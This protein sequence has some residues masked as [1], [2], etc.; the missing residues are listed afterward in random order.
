MKMKKQY[1]ALPVVAG[2]VGWAALDKTPTN[3]TDFYPLR[4]QESVTVDV[5]VTPA[6]QPLLVSQAATDVKLAKKLGFAQHLPKDVEFLLGAYDLMGQFNSFRKSKLGKVIEKRMADAGAKIDDILN[7]QEII[8]FTDIAGEEVFLSV[9]YGGGEQFG[10]FLTV[11]DFYTKF[12]TSMMIQ[13]LAIEMDPD[14]NEEGRMMEKQNALANAFK[15]FLED[16]KGG[17]GFLNKLDTPP[18]YAGF[19]VTNKDNRENYTEMLQGFFEVPLAQQDDDFKV[20]EEVK[21]KRGGGEFTGFK[22][23]GK[24]LSGQMKGREF[25]EMESLFGAKA[26]RDLKDTVSKK[27]FYAVVGN[28]GDHVVFFFGASLDDFKL[29]ENVGESLLA[30]SD[31]KFAHEFADKEILS[32]VYASEGMTSRSLEQRP[33]GAYAEGLKLGLENT[34]VFGDTRDFEGLVDHVAETADDLSD[35]SKAKRLGAVVYLEDGLKI[36]VRG[37]SNSPQLD[38]ETNR[39]LAG[40]DKPGET[41]FF[42]NWVS[43]PVYTDKAFKFIDALGAAA[44]TGAKRVAGLDIDNRDFKEFKQGFELFETKLK[45][46]AMKIWTVVR[47][48]LP[49]GLGNEGA[50]VVDVLGTMPTVPEAPEALVKKLKIPRVAYVSDVTDRSKLKV[51]WENLNAAAEGIL[52]FVK[53]MGGPEIPMQKPNSSKSD[54]L[55]TYSFQ[56]PSSHM[57]CNPSLSVSDKLFML[58]TSPEFSKALNKRYEAK[59]VDPG[60]VMRLDFRLLSKYADDLIE[61]ADKNSDDIFPQEHMRAQFKEGIKP[62]VSDILKAAED[63]QSLTAQTVE[64]GSEVRSTIHLKV[65]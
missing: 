22:L 47:S 45:K 29:A 13:M 43:N 2:V 57:N 26:M 25:E 38:L 62:I 44:F 16:P 40:L 48:D 49:Q 31:F 17:A 1:M 21:V 3:Q 9:G 10:N 46:D 52:K 4:P 24:L 8:T 12:S 15:G 59:G 20:F 55:M 28:V 61:L 60:A 30:K 65:K 41:I 6:F 50:I 33:M 64:K 19:K 56:I 27:D 53:E 63:F 58:S 36:D 14:Q 11:G 51:S 54:G 5:Q 37:G 34:D 7:E 42:A 35:M 23:N 39:N 32:V 18:I